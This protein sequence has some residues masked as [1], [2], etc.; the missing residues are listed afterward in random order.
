LPR[1]TFFLKKNKK[2]QFQMKTKASFPAFKIVQKY[3]FL[4]GAAFEPTDTNF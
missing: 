1:Q 3:F 2:K 4:G